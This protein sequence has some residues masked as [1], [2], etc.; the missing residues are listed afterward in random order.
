MCAWTIFENSL[1]LYCA[2]FS[3]RVLLIFFLLAFKPYFSLSPSLSFSLIISPNGFS[4]CFSFPHC[5]Y[6]TLVLSVFLFVSFAAAGCHNFPSF[7]APA[8]FVV[9]RLLCYF[10]HFMIDREHTYRAI[11]TQGAIWTQKINAKQQTEIENVKRIQRMRQGAKHVHTYK[12]RCV[13]IHD[14][15]TS[16]RE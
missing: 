7:N 5:A 12:A 6:M 16:E 4:W 11:G 8:V 1:T 3:L 14:K 13:R 15:H 9:G 10:E 2:S